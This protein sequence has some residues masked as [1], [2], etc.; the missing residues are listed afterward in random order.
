MHD[1][2]SATKR[3]ERHSGAKGNRVSEV[4]S[5]PEVTTI[6]A[7]ATAT[8]TA[9]PAH[10]RRGIAY[11]LARLAVLFLL[12][13]LVMRFTGLTESFVFYF[14]SREAFTNPRG[15]EDVWFNT[16]DG[17][18]LHGWFIPAADAAPG[19]QRPTILHC[20]GNAGNVESH[21]SFS[22]FLTR[23]GFHVFIFDYR[24]YGRSDA[25][26][27]LSRSDLAID[28]LAAFDS[29]AARPDVDPRRI[30]LYGVSLGAVFALRVAEL[31][32]DAACVCTVAA[33]SSWGGVAGDHAP[34]LGPLL[35]GRGLDP[36]S[37]VPKLG[38]RPYLIIHGVAD[39]IVP[40]RHADVLEAAANNA[41]V[42]VRV[43]RIDCGDH[44]G[45]TD[46]RE[47]QTAIA[48]FFTTSLSPKK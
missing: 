21:L 24:G 9:A 30:G 44:N 1:E 42:P 46:G 2:A 7:T 5:V 47:A 20:H 4:Q 23:R 19:E 15:A 26:R 22:S 29:L 11:R 36:M 39:T 37:L 28:A 14:P 35:I 16:P 17:K 38:T 32:P 45:V 27:R 34:F 12:V 18:R 48:D 6:T 41:N 8:A 10:R 25:A 43:V 33:F 13:G 40:C 31:R 3:Q